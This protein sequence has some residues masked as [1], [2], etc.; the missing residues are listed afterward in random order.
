M[1]KKT[2]IITIILGL[3]LLC[4]LLFQKPHIATDETELYSYLLGSMMDSNDE[5]VA[6]I[7]ANDDQEEK[8]FDLFMHIGD[9]S[10][11]GEDFSDCTIVEQNFYMLYNFHGEVGNGGVEQFIYNYYYNYE[12]ALESFQD[13]NLPVTSQYLQAACNIYPDKRIEMY[14]DDNLSNR[15]SII[16][17]QYYDLHDQEFNDVINDYVEQNKDQFR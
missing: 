5:N 16:D 2:I 13:M 17:E 10:N 7:L 4:F 12:F 3:S 11:Y 8:L 15:L 9:K 14:S 6:D 1:S